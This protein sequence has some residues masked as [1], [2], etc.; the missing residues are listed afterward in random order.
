MHALRFLSRSLLRRCAPHV[1]RRLLASLPGRL[2][3]I[4]GFGWTRSASCLAMVRTRVARALFA[5][6]L[7][8]ASFAR[9][10]S[11]A[12]KLHNAPL[13]AG[14][15]RARCAPHNPSLCKMAAAPSLCSSRCSAPGAAFTGSC[16]LRVCAP[17]LACFG[18]FLRVS[19]RASCARS[20]R[21]NRCAVQSCPE[22]VEGPTA[23]QGVKVS[24]RVADVVSG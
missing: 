5:C 7:R 15:A 14:C 1:A 23:Q 10:P 21:L 17:S 18:R 24:K 13:C 20:R 8:R 4:S 3:C 11:P 19:T 22:L 16:T 9:V 2:R 6:Q 12:A